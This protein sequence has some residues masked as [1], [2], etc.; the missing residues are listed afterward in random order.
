MTPWPGWTAERTLILPLDEPPPARPIRL[1][2]VLL[3]PKH[4]LHL[5][6][7]GRTLGERLHAAFDPGYL[8][9]AL[10]ARFEALDWTIRREG[11][12][13]LLRKPALRDDGERGA[14]HSVIE[15]V[16]APALAAFHRTVERLLGRTLPRPPPHITLYTEGRRKGIGVPAESALR[17]FTVRQVA[18]EEIEAAARAASG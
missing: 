2:G 11:V 18:R 3:Q 9:S 12:F 13:L 15:R 14:V 17:A 4:E 10:R 6:L 7:L 5:T 1:D 8:T 16:Q